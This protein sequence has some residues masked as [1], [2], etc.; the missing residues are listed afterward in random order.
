MQVGNS[1]KLLG[2]QSTVEG[3]QS[4]DTT[5]FAFQVG[6]H[7]VDVGSQVFEQR[8]CE[9]A[10]EHRDADMRILTGQR[11]DYWYHHGHVAH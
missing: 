7:E 3:I 5:I 8:T 9:G 11:I 4:C 10:T 1:S 2:S 6:Y